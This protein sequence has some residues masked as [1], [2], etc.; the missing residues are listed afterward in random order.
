MPLN[1]SDRRTDHDQSKILNERTTF[2]ALETMTPALAPPGTAEPA[3]ATVESPAVAPFNRCRRFNPTGKV[4][5]FT[6]PPG[7]TT[8]NARCW[9]GG[10]KRNGSGGGGFATGDIAVRPGETLLVV[11][12]MGGGSP[13]GGGMS[14]LYSQRFGKPLLIAGGGGRSF[15]DVPGGAGGGTRGSDG[16]LRMKEYKGTT[17]QGA[18]GSTGGKGA[19]PADKHTDNFGGRGGDTGQNGGSSAGKDAGGQVPIPGMGGGGGGSGAGGGGGGYAGGGGGL[20]LGYRTSAFVGGGAGGSS[21]VAGPGVTSGRTLPGTGT[22]AG[23]KGDPAYQAGVGDANRHGQVVLQW[24]EFT[25]TPGSD[26]QLTQGGAE[27]F[28][29]LRV[30]STDGLEPVTVTVTLPAGRRLLWGT[31]AQADYQLTVQRS[32]G[33]QTAYVGALSGDGDALTFTDVDLHLPGTTTIWVCVSADHDAP[34]GPTALTFD[35]AGKKSHSTR[36][37]VKP[38]ITVSASGT[39]VLAP[40]GGERTYPGVKVRNNGAATIPPLTVVATLPSGFRWGGPDGPDHQLT[41][42]AG[43]RGTAVHTGVFSADET[44]LTFPD[45]D[46]LVGGA[47]GTESIMW[48]GVSPTEH[49]PTGAATVAFTVGDHVSPSTTMNVT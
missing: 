46:L 14:G 36:I 40:R 2:M 19:A 30:A 11:V 8:I 24:T 45:V 10:G 15:D 9:G 34:L 27:A 37:L 38:A 29:G 43:D 39:P 31:Q 28:P 49:A 33:A 42:S 32:D 18:S 44:V 1:E 16:T 5:N 17:A 6:V 7:V 35:V 48:V 26:K 22:Q 23:G 3:P 4:Q 41:V 12:D 20:G 47:A 21:F 13:G 25:L